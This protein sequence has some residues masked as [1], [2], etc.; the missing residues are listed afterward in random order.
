LNATDSA[1]SHSESA[2]KLRRWQQIT[3]ISLFVGYAGYYLGRSCLAIANP[4]MVE[5]ESAHGLT[6]ER[7]GLIYSVGVLTYAVGKVVNGL[8]VDYIGGRQMFLFGMVATVACTAAFGMSTALPVLVVVW[9]ANRF[10]QSMGWNA[11]VKTASRWYPAHRQATIMGFLSLSFLFGD[12]IDRGY[13]GGLVAIGQRFPHSPFAVLANW[14]NVFLIAS[15]TLGVIAVALAFVLRSSPKELGLE[16]PSA[17]PEN[18]FGQAGQSA[19]TVPFL[20]LLLPLIESP[21][22]WSICGVS[23]GL[24]LIREAFNNWSSTILNDVAGL[25]A[26]QAGIASLIFPLA[27]GVGALGAGMLSD[28]WG[29]RH[30]RIVVPS[31]IVLIFSLG[32]MAVINVTGRPFLAMALLAVTSFF[33]IAPYSYLSG[34]MALDLGGKRGSATAAGL[35]DGAGYVGG[36][37]SGWGIAKIAGRYEWSGVFLSLA[38]VCCLTLV[39]AVAYLILSERAKSAHLAAQNIES[40]ESRA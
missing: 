11:L 24:T 23:F 9:G 13:L 15:A 20:E 39:V 6:K 32:S 33:L 30:G 37:A 10:F 31:L 21:M 28:R 17:N 5:Q 12:A 14:R 34:V 27:G 8:I 7:I 18:V 4:L 35:I 1:L 38:G 16:E 22:F 2:A 36:I 25:Q 19:D 40:E 3:G 29:G 26:G